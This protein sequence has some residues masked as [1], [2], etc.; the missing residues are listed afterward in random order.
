MRAFIGAAILAA[1]AT[2]AGSTPALA[3]HTHLH[4]LTTP[5]TMT[6]IAGG[7][8]ANGPH[9]AFSTFHSQ[10]HLVALRSSGNLFVVPS[11]TGSC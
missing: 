7:L 10:V 4:C 8:T 1:A 11:F 3:E 9:D 5:G 2:L 6:A